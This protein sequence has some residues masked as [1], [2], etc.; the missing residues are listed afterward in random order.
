M[1][2]SIRQPAPNKCV[3]PKKTIERVEI[4]TS[5]SS[6]LQTRLWVQQW[7]EEGD[8]HAVFVAHLFPGK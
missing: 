6:S 3:D 8:S 7:L 4:R 5:D 1:N 2:V